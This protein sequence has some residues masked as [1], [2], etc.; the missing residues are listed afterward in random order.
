MKFIDTR[1]III[2]SELFKIVTN[3]V[4]KISHNEKK[5]TIFAKKSMFLALSD[6]KPLFI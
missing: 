6:K 1:K 4:I 5:K 2:I 3:R